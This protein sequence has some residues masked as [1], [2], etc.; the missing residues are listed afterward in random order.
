MAKKRVEIS[1]EWWCATIEI[2]ESES[3]MA[4]MKE[5]LLFWSGGQDRI[6]RH[7]GDIEKAYLKMLASHMI[8]ESINCTQEGVAIAFDDEE[9]WYP[10]RG[11]NGV[12][13][14]NCDSW[15]FS[16]EDFDIKQLREKIPLGKLQ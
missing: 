6:D 12:N 3:T 15:E 10:I 2:D 14:I 13:L 9:G 7:G 11:K 1:F 5:Q 16:D 4:T 8:F